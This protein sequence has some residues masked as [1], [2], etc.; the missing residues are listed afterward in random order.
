DG[1]AMPAVITTVSDV[2]YFSFQV[3]EDSRV[4]FTVDLPE[5]NNLDATL[6]LRDQNGQLIISA[7]PDD[8][9]GAKIVANL[10]AGVYFVDIGSQGQY[11]DVGQYSITAHALSASVSGTVFLDGDH[12]GVRDTG[13]N[14][15]SGWVLYD[16]RNQNGTLD[17]PSQ[18]TWNST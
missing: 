5:R 4:T 8:S 13:E 9:Y 17:A 14:G 11:G 12:D 3:N 16:D 2:D 15:L 18:S 6:E 10:E 1:V 7:A